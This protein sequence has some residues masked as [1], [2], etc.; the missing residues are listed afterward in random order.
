MSLDNAVSVII[1]TLATTERGKF[2]FQTIDSVLMQRDV[3][4]IPIVIANGRLFDPTIIKELEARNDLKYVYLEKASQPTAIQAGRN[5]VE[6]TFFSILDDDDLL[7]PHAMATRLQPMQNDQDTD[8]VVTSGIIY[9]SNN[10][11]ST[12]VNIIDFQEI[13]K[14]PLRRINQRWM[15]TGAC[16]FRT[17]TVDQAIFEGMPP[18]LEWTYMAVRLCLAKKKL[19]FINDPTIVHFV[20]HPFSVD[21]SRQAILGRPE[22]LKQILA[23]EMP[24]DVRVIFEA[25]LGAAYYKVSQVHLR[26]LNFRLAWS[27]HMKMVKYKGW[28]NLLF[29]GGLYRK[30]KT[31]LRNSRAKTI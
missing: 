13:T 18:Y 30:T 25:Y 31:L 2:L 15:L 11:N 8:V 17:A 16:L 24:R 10:P 9:Q 19:S 27:A 12:T 26:D 28:K 6:T 7:F 4:T 22:S 23:L 3:Q 5:L 1:P 21:R 29:I 20:D 14:D